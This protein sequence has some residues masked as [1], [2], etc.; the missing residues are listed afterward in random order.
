M[1]DGV[2]LALDVGGFAPGLGI[3]FDLAN[4]GI[5]L[6]R[7]NYEDAITNLIATIPGFG[8]SVKIVKMA[9]ATG[10]PAVAAAAALS[11]LNKTAQSP[12]WSSK[13]N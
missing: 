4:A 2:Q 8:D 7:G 9:A 12:L 6:G 13:K 11:K 5:S 10:R 3:I 1:L